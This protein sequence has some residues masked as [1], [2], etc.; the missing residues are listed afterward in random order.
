[1][2]KKLFDDNNNDPFDYFKEEGSTKKPGESDPDNLVSSMRS[3]IELVSDTEPSKKSL[4]SRINRK[5]IVGVLLGVFIIWLF[6]YFIAGSGRSMLERNL[7]LLVHL[8]ATTTPTSQPTSPPKTSTPEPTDT[9]RPSPTIQP[10]LTSTPKPRATVT[11]QSAEATATSISECRDVLSITLADVGKTLCVR[12]TII[13]TVESPN[14]FMVVFSDQPGAF[15]WASYDMVW[16]QAEIG[17]CYEI[18]GTIEQIGNNPIL[19]FNYHN[20]PE[21]CP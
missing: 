1:M 8:S 6:V 3:D 13:R 4:L 21:V 2:G 14:A 7:A 10:T 15:Y 20:I 5:A 19:L 16:K 18:T 11:L 9:P 17:T 12:G